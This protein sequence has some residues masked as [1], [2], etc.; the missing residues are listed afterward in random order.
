[1]MSTAARPEA[2]LR[3]SP[4]RD[5]RHVGDDLF[6]FLT[7]FVGRAGRSKR[8]IQR[9]RDGVQGRSDLLIGALERGHQA[10]NRSAR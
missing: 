1:M 4:L 6:G 2:R 10:L 5:R 9:V 7:L 8:E 3:A